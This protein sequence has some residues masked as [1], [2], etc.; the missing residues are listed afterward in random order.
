MKIFTGCGY[1]VHKFIEERKLKLGGVEIPYDM[2]LLGH[3]DADVLLHAIMDSLLSAAGLKD[4]GW[5]FPNSD[6]QYFGISSLTL[7]EKVLKILADNGYIPNNVSAQIICEKPVL[8]DYIDNMRENIAN[9]LK[10]D[11]KRVAVMATTNEGLGFV[12]RNE[13]IAV[14]ANSSIIEK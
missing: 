9:A 13:G 3:S 11:I 1:D 2:G 8:K 10:I 14:I 4:I 6:M 12:G 5:H 7:L